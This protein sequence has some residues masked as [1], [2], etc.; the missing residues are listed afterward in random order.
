MGERARY[1]I[2]INGVWYGAGDIIPT[3]PLPDTERADTEPE[4]EQSEPAKRYTRTDIYRMSTAEL[5]DLAAER[6]IENA[7]QLTGKEL[8]ERLIADFGD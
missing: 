8:K 3:V 6:G 5:R 1:N 2:K 7:L 4:N